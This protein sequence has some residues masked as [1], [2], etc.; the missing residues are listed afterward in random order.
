MIPNLFYLPLG[1]TYSVGNQR[2]AHWNS[3]I[4]YKVLSLKSLIT[5]LPGLCL[6]YVRGNNV[7]IYWLPTV[8]EALIHV[9][10]L[11]LHNSSIR[12]IFLQ[13]RK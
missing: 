1:S 4:I 12:E 8:C 11:N 9:I 13:R 2:V 6:N 5:L 7:N 10:L 3:K